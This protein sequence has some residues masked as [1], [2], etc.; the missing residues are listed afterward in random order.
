MKRSGL[1][2]I[3]VVPGSIAEE[4][5][6]EKGDRVKAI[7]NMPVRDLIDFRYL[8]AEEILHVDITKSGGEEWVLEIEKDIDQ[9]LGLDF[10]AGGFGPT[11][12]CINKCV[13][14][15]VDQMPPGMRRTL[16]VKDD[17]YRH[18]FWNG[19][20]ITLTNLSKRMLKRIA[21]QRLS[22]L[23]I[24]VHTTN[25]VLREKMLGC[26]RA[27]SIMEQLR[28]LA[29]SGIEMHTQ[30]VLCPGL[31]DAE[32][33]DKTVADLSSL[34]PSVRSLAVV[35]VGLTRFRD[36][37]YPLDVFDVD[38]ARELIRWIHARQKEFMTR[39]K[40][41]FIFASDEFYLLAGKAIPAAERYDGFPQVENG[42]GLTRIFLD[43]W[44]EVEGGLPTETAEQKIVLITGVLGE[45]I[46]K[47]VAERLNKI[48]GLQ[49]AV[50]TVENDFFGGQ[51][52]ATGLVT[53]HDILKQVLP[54]EAG[55]LLL[56]PS[57][58]LK[59][60]EPVFLDNL[61]L[62][63]LAESIKARVAVVAGPRQLADVLIN[64]PQKAKIFID[65]ASDI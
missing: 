43:E 59:E 57:V 42:V 30:V 12:R 45:N 22:P 63:D 20:F 5:G 8:E 46:V 53:G 11:I 35:P 61:G 19:N 18:S 65:K 48:A 44:A 4:M 23:Y 28:F 64:G 14:C 40:H 2:I 6:L 32:E 34:W 55:D 9:D 29:E 39:F 16:Y 54:G 58:M 51:V 24:S 31:N 17:D 36:N 21:A 15:F 27:G 3:T 33:L 26:A 10:G 7:N 37:L 50:K 60:D 62:A 1:K 41:P 49:V 52:T 56:L 25:P 47:P 13:F 38:K